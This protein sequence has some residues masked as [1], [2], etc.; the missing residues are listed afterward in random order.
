MTK[1]ITRTEDGTLVSD[2]TLY[3]GLIGRINELGPHGFRA[4][5]WH[6]GESD[7][8]QP[9]EHEISA[10]IYAQMMTQLIKSARR[11]AGWDFPW[12][13]AVA[14]YHSPTDTS[15]PELR[16]AQRSLWKS[17]VALEGPDTD[18][19]IGSHRE[20]GGKG[21]HLSAQGLQAHGRMWAGKVSVYL[22]PILREST[23][24]KK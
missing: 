17:G 15:S 7:T 11:D 14:S 13:V 3:R 20:N 6:Q 10:A 1:F 23:P 22:D 2:G 21:V 4:L 5:L 24:M 12:F 19:L 9:P 18:T 8:H 16:E